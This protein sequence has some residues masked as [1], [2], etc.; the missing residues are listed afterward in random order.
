M[1]SSG[2]PEPG[3]RAHEPASSLNFLLIKMLKFVFEPASSLMEKKLAEPG[4]YLLR[5]KILARASKPEPRLV[6]PL[7]VLSR[8]NLSLH[9]VIT[10]TCVGHWVER[11]HIYRA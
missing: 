10:L 11:T 1:S 5:A 3:H 9:L 2:E 4:A 6:P 8:L 7:V